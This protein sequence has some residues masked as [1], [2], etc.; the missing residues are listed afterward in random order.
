MALLA[1]PIKVEL[2]EVLGATANCGQWGILGVHGPMYHRPR[3]KVSIDVSQM[4]H[5]PAGNWTQI[6]QLGVAEKNE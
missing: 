3:E 5:F 2:G 4:L 6:G 1:I